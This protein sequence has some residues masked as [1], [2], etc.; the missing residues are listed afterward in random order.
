MRNTSRGW[1]FAW[2]ALTISFALHVWDEAAHDFLS[3]YN[4]TVESIRARWPVIPLPTFTFG[5]WLTGLS[6]AIVVLALLAPVAF[7]GRA[8]L[9]SIAYPYSVIMLVNGVLHIAVSLY[10]AR[11]MPGVWS[12]PFLLISSVALL[13]ATR[14][15][16]GAA[17]GIH[18]G[19]VDERQRS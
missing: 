8:S 18:S 13:F 15:A 16:T 3:I 17:E 11:P 12:S 4:P 19:M 9:K 1:G 5:V 7:H 6:L 2:V 14:R 10:L